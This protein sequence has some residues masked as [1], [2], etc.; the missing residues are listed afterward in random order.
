VC[1]AD[2]R[3]PVVAVVIVLLGWTAL[4]AWAEVPSRT[5]GGQTLAVPQEQ[6]NSGEV[7]YIRPH[8]GT[9]LLWR[10][11]GP[12]LHAAAVC[13]RV[14]GYM[15]T[16]F[17]LEEDPKPLLGGAFRIPVASL[18]TG[19]AS[20]D[21]G[22][23]SARML[24]A[25]EY[26]EIMLEITGVAD[27]EP[28]GEEDGRRGYTFKLSADLT[29]KDKTVSIEAPARATFVPFTWQ[30][31]PLGM[32]DALILR[33]SFDVQRAELGLHRPPGQ[34]DYTGPVISIDLYLLGNTMSPERNMYANIKNENHIKQFKFLT[35]VRDFDDREK[36]Y[37]FGRQYM[38]EIWDDSV[39]LDRLAAATLELER[40]ES[41][42]LAFAL[43][44]AQRAN[45]LTGY[46]DPILL[47]TLALAH[48]E[49]G[50]LDEALK[51]S[52]QAV[53]HIEA[54]GPELGPG[55][56]AALQRYEVE[57]EKHSE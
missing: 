24:N 17:D 57:A 1:R 52:R 25:A 42:D 39:A 2:S 32:S 5:E 3:L 51:R 50:N 28:A 53:E 14:V 43:K 35:L 37:A 40:S 34:P 18:R 54:A 36:G 46:G 31:V 47:N 29:V 44:A 55:I 45:E 33:T 19:V 16:P 56:R 38:K 26:P 7:Y 20:M 11:D 4:C 48:H 49:M 10:S 41:R 13:N 6:L 9:Q 30:T 21:G 23:H 8:F 12:L 22:L 27:V 15:I